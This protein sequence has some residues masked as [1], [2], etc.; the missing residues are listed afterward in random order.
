[1][2]TSGFWVPREEGHVVFF[3]GLVWS[4]CVFQAMLYGE[5]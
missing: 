5:L 4:T 3:A 1:M 2:R